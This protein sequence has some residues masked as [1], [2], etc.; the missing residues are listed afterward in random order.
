MANHQIHPG[1][2]IVTTVRGRTWILIVS[3]V[4]NGC[5]EATR[6]GRAY[7]V[8]IGGSIERGESVHVPGHGFAAIGRPTTV[9]SLAR[10]APYNL[11][12]VR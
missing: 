1:D 6:N 2:R 5:I 3:S 12:R 11:A 7:S 4:V 8:V 9:G 10:S